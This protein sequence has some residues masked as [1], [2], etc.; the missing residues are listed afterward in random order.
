MEDS[1]I[2]MKNKELNKELNNKGYMYLPL[3]AISLHLEFIL[4][5]LKSK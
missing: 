2:P 5:K 4:A 1:I 3:R